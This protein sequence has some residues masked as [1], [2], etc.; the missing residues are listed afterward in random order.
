MARPMTDKAAFRINDRYDSEDKTKGY[1]RTYELFDEQLQQ[2]A[3]CCD[4]MGN[5]ALRKQEIITENGE[6]WQLQPNRKIMPSLWMLNDSSGQTRWQFRQKAWGKLVNPFHK[7]LMTVLDGDDCEL[8]QLVDLH[9][10]KPAVIVGLEWGKYALVKGDQPLA[11]LTSLPRENPPQAKGLMGAI[12]RFLNSSDTA[13]ISTGSKHP[14]PAPAALAIY[15]LYKE[16]TDVSRV[17]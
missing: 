2:V 6:R 15:L 12:R 13:L 5:A 8:M 7:T 4:L 10:T 11:T 3:A 9:G 1:E 14:L 17:G 16:F